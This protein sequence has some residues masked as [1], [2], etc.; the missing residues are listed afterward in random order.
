VS[1]GGPVPPPPPLPG[2]AY[3]PPPPPPPRSTGGGAPPPP[4]PTPSA[5][6]AGAF[7]DETIDPPDAT[8]PDGAER[9]ERAAF[10]VTEQTRTYPCRQCGA[11]LVFDIT[12]QK[13]ACPSCGFET[14]I[15]TTGLVAPEERD[16]QN[17]VRQI[18]SFAA[19][20]QAAPQVQGEKEIVC[21]NCGGHTTFSG[22]LTATRCPYCATPIQRDDVHDAPSRLVVDGVLPFQVDKKRAT[23]QIE[24]WINSRWFAPTEFK[25]YNEK[26][27]F[28]SIYAAYF[29]FDSQ[30][31]TAY[32]G[33]RGDTYTV[34]VG[35]GENQRTETR[36]RWT[37][38]SGVVAD[39]FDDIAVLAN[40]GF[41]L[42]RVK[43][44]EPWPTQQASPFSP[45]YVAGHLCR[46]YDHDVEAC[47]PAARTEMDRAIE[48][49]VRRDIGGDQQRISSLDTRHLT[50]TFKHLLL[51]IWLLTVIYE[52]K[53]FQ[54]F[55]NGVTGEVQGDRPWS[56]VKIA[57]AV[58]A[59]LIVVIAIVA[60][61]SASQ[62]SS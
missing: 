33:Q 28:T 19:T 6:D 14:D 2:G 35:S 21:Q 45:E 46:T 58:I 20:A 41:D 59:A 52:G 3:P 15:D 32:S 51:P 56:K 23:E 47:Y 48:Q 9:V 7:P 61:Y 16:F 44:L 10:Q 17:T 5:G 22:T 60:A 57:L 34:T 30:T 38:R 12:K 55:I 27:S 4:P 25:K 26:G 42:K 13:L 1:D 11:Q 50:L 37:P 31:R 18:R 40:E 29:T 24:K 53:P 39:A 54:V 8:E 62:G 49:T 36:V 43:D